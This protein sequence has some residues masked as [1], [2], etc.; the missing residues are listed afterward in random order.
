MENFD[1]KLKEWGRKV[2]DFCNEI[3]TNEEYELNLHFYAFQSAPKQNPDLLI[4]GINPGE[5]HEYK[6]K[7]SVEKFIEANPFFCNHKD[8]A[9]WK[10]LSISF[11]SIPEILEESMC[12]NLVYFNTDNLQNLLKRKGGKEGFVKCKGFSLDL[13]SEVIRPKCILC[14]G[15]A[16]CFD[17]LPIE[18]K[19]VLLK[20][21]M[22]LLVKGEFNGIPT[23]AMP[24]PSG[25]RV[26]NVNRKEIGK[27]LKECL[28]SI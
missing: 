28:Q 13:I 27:K 4:L 16:T 21:R 24:H 20:S 23:Y 12:M 10:R 9:M 6:G 2:V 11:E 18:N 8:W 26:S 5:E 3:A 15:T 7:I 17:Y 25:A 22:R 19:E 14:L 1:K